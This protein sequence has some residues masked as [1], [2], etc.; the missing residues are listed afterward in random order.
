[1]DTKKTK[2]NV[3]PILLLRDI[4]VFPSMVIPLF[5]GRKKSIM[6]VESA[7]KNDNPILLL[8]QKDSKIDNPKLNDF[9]H[10][11]TL[12]HILQFLR[13][14]DGTVKVLVEGKK[15]GHC[16]KIIE[17]SFYTARFEPLIDQDTANKDIKPLTKALLQEF[18]YYVKLSKKLPPE[19]LNSVQ[20]IESPV[21]LIDTVA[22]HLPLKIEQKQ[23]LIEIR[24]V[25][26]R[27][28]K[29]CLF[30]AKEVESLNAE[31]RVRNRVK[32]QMEK[33]QREYYL[34]E[35]MRAIQKELGESD[36]G[37]NEFDE[38]EEKIKKTKLSKE[39]RKK[40]ESELKKLRM[41]SP[42]AA[43]A[44]VLRNYLEWI[45]DIPWKKR[46]KLKH[47]LQ[48][49]EDMLE[50]DHYGLDKIKERVLEYLA[51]QERVGKVPGQILCFVGPPG[52]GKTSLGKSIA[53]A[54]GRKFHRIALGGVR[55]EAEIRGHRRTYI[56]SQ[57]GKIM[58]GMRKVQASNPLI[59]LDEIDKLGSDWRGDPTSAL[60]EVLDPEQNT[61]F[62]DHYLEVDYDL[63]DVMFI[64]TANT[65]NMPQPL[66]DRMEIIR[67]AGYT[68]DEKKEI[69]LQYLIPKQMK[70]HG[71][72]KKD[73]ALNDDALPTIIHAYTQEAGVRNLEREISR[74]CRKVVKKLMYKKEKKI[75]IN[76]KNLKDYLGQKKY[77]HQ[78]SEKEDAIGVCTGLAWT[79]FGGE[80]LTIESVLVPGKG[81][82]KA[83]GKLG[84]VM[85]ESVQAA[86]SFVKSRYQELGIDPS[87]FEKNDIHVHV[88]EGATP[89]EGPSAGT[90][91]CT[92]LVSLLTGVA[93]KKG[94]AMT[95]EVTLRGHVLP[96]GGLK[97][98][99]LAAHRAGV[100]T[101]FIPK[102][103]EKDLEDIPQSSKNDIS[104]IPVENAMEVLNKI[105]LSPPKSFSDE[106][107]K[108]LKE[109]TLNKKNV[110]ETHQF[111][112]H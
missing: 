28:E 49:A 21:R 40:A 60:L 79:Q 34:N 56:G 44:T 30:I 88:P 98:K 47:N 31:N 96:I 77:R 85:Q 42:M 48:K 86:Y 12:G 61:R 67:L 45:L 26:E 108:S 15:R 36:N 52:V 35:Q 89:K 65:L 27:L 78:L 76:I 92:T 81:R 99:I 80:L 66:L 41:M 11:G 73:F 94:T 54:I 105:L 68:D 2:S 95:G 110:S 101:I 37:K 38:L 16:Q 62:S 59:L 10:T 104:I 74:I 70:K 22:S 71:L 109:A 20:I 8:T 51:V 50:A 1:M 102:D 106:K 103:N 9:Y 25:L 87:I 63:S 82:I 97:E 69:A 17:N 33:S 3:S 39:A 64:T 72:E 83:T 24:S 7:M 32:R 93:V 43:E 55:D 13:L 75:N 18:E 23:E 19:I 107:L 84:E 5:V 100:K 6:A 29:I 111:V 53:E 91:I 57:P 14:P 112:P 46:T 4:V 58:Q 90:A